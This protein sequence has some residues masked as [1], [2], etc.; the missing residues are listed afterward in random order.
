MNSRRAWIVYSV[1]RILF[2]AVPFALVYALG[3]SLQFSMMMSAVVAVVLAALIGFSLSLLFLSKSRNAASE[4][5]Y[6]WRNRERTADDVEEDDA[7]AESSA[8]DDAT[9]E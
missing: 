1:L 5:I 6:D 4:T 9:R 8:S 3:L 2:F 7:I